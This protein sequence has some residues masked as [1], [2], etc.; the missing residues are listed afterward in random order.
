M[1]FAVDLH[2][3]TA[4]SPCGDEDMTPNNIV[5]MALLKG[6]DLIAVTDHNC[7]ANLEA[8]I[9]AGRNKGLLVIPGI[10]VQSKEEVHLICLFKNLTKACEFGDL[11]YDSLP[12]IANN[13][14]LFGKQLIID[15]SDTVIGKV[16]KLLLSSSNYS[17]NEI[18]KIVRDFDGLCIP[19][20]IDRPGYS[21]ISNLGFIPNDLEVRIVEVSR[22]ITAE[23]ILS[24][25]A[26][27]K[28]YK[29]VVSSDAHYL[30]DISE[31]D[32]FVD[33]EYLSPSQLFEALQGFK[34]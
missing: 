25:M 8:V 29:Q 9:D 4:L 3:H 6:L 23:N 11:I 20:H 16:D 28:N 12:N 1:K 18:F 26:F 27:I 32:Y 19:A 31:R 22:K 34:L 21:M 2:I 15:A 24:K 17:V 5:N 14:E 33:M 10:E 7:C 30:W 13:E